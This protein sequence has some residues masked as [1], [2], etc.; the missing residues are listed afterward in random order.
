MIKQQVSEN[1]KTV[2]VSGVDVPVLVHRV[3]LNDVPVMLDLKE[4]TIELPKEVFA[5]I[6]DEY[7]WPYKEY[8]NC[9]EIYMNFE[10]GHIVVTEFKKHD[11]TEKV[12]LDVF[13]NKYTLSK[14]IQ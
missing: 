14:T 4:G 8:K 2:V 6:K 1:M 13:E 9:I 5:L 10:G 11:D 12:E 7:D 3:I